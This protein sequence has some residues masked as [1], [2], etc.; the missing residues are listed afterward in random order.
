MKRE[1]KPTAYQ[2]AEIDRL[3]FPGVA[4][5]ESEK[6]IAEIAKLTDTVL[7]SFSGGK[8]AI[9][10]WLAL[11]PHFKRIIPYYYYLVPDLEFVEE[12]L[13][14]YEDFF[15]TRILRY[16]NPNLYRMLNNEVFQPPEH[17]PVIRA[18]SLPNFDYD[19]LRDV[20]CDDLGIPT[21][22]FTANGVRAS[23]SLNRRT[24]FKTHGP[25]NYN[26]RMFYPIWDWKKAALMDCFTKAG[27]KMPVDYQ[28]F[29]R[30]FDGLDFRFVY[31]IRKYFPR[32][33]AR[34]REFF[35]MIEVEFKR[36]EYAQAHKSHTA[37]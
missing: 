27:I 37:L 35:P 12:S 21:D 29:G 3:R 30:S 13:R 10:A 8:D 24:M 14:Y 33:Y 28:I 9:A 19:E 25:V 15:G 17:L 22:T 11:R 6:V 1:A 34:I 5:K 32:D 31:P 16:P 4:V 7:L 23:D 36:Y 18:W 20:I 26:R 2:L